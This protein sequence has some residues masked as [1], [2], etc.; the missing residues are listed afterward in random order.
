MDKELI[1]RLAD[2]V[3]LPP[4]DH[5]VVIAAQFV[6]A[7]C[8]KV[9]DGAEVGDDSPDWNAAAMTMSER[10]AAAIRAKFGVKE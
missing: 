7:E 2:V 8:A 3:G 4:D 10:I 9:A 5:A 1:E 6:A